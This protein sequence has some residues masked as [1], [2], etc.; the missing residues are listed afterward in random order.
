MSLLLCAAESLVVKHRNPP[1]AAALDRT[2]FA[3]QSMCC[4]LTE[5]IGSTVPRR[6]QFAQYRLVGPGEDAGNR[7]HS[8]KNAEDMRYVF[9]A[10]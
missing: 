2:Y 10:A 6:P 4:W 7:N 8:M 9:W 3:M 5:N 1:I